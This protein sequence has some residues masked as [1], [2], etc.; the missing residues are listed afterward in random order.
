MITIKID[1]FDISKLP[2]NCQDKNS[3]AFTM[4]VKV[5]FENDYGKSGLF[6]SESG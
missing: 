1:D 3:D 4:A 5:Y 2:G 6:A